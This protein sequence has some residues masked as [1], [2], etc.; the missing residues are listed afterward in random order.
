MLLKQSYGW[1][2]SLLFKG[3]GAGVGAGEKKTRIRSKTD[4]LRNTDFARGHSMFQANPASFTPAWNTTYTGIPLVSTGTL[5][6]S[7]EV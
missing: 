2:E 6:E 1:I 7:R 3:A 5:D 4:R